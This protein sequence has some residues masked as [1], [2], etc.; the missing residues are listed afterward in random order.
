MRWMDI[1]RGGAV[2]LVVFF[3]AGNTSQA[4]QLVQMAN[5]GLGSYRLA[6]LF[7]ASGL[8]LE[9]SLAKGLVRF[10]AGKLRYLMWPYLVWT[11]LIMLPLIGLSRGLD[12]AWWI[13]PRGSHTWFLIA[14]ATVYAV[15]YLTRFIPPGWLVLAFLVTSQLIDRKEFELGAF[16]HDVSWWGTFFFLGVVLARNIDAVLSAPVW[17][18]LIGAAITV[19][20]F[21]LNAL[22]DAPAAKTLLAAVMTAIGVGTVVWALARL[23]RVWPFTLLEWLGRFSIVTY[24]VHVPVLRIAVNYLGWPRDSWIGFLSL[25]LTVL[26]VCIVTTRCYPQLRWLFEWPGAARSRR[27]AP[28]PLTVPQPGVPVT[29]RR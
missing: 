29:Q 2:V 5:D 12:P 19:V 1:L 22:P 7:F 16:V 15:G 17:V 11:G 18:F 13:Y 14:L 25:A 3:H 28:A 24:L 8:L 6:A 26:L 9:R 21:V 20:W 23:P 27:P 4:P 10:S